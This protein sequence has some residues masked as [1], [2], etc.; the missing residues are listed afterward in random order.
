MATINTFEYN[1]AKFLI[2]VPEPFT[3]NE[4][5]INGFF[6]FAKEIAAYDRLFYIKARIYISFL[7]Q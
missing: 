6:N 1:I 3:H 2:P 7:L 5:T 4:F